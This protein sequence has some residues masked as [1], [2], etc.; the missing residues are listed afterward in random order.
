M[1][2]DSEFIAYFEAK[3]SEVSNRAVWA[4]TFP[5]GKYFAFRR[6][7]LPDGIAPDRLVYIRLRAN[8]SYQGYLELAEDVAAHGPSENP[9]LSSLG[10]P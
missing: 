3:R 5:A 7:A 1:I 8:G 10:V 6:V 9:R 4:G 2:S